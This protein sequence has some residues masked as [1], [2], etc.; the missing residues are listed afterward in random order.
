MALIQQW[1]Y[2]DLWECLFLLDVVSVL[3]LLMS[4]AELSLTLMGSRFVLLD[5]VCP[6]C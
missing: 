6:F 4:V 5:T 1:S 3:T 2:C